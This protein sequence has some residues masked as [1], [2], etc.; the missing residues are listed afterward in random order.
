MARS[1]HALLA[2]EMPRQVLL[3]S[4]AALL[5]LELELMRLV[6]PAEKHSLIQFVR[7]TI[8]LFVLLADICM[9]LEGR[10]GMMICQGLF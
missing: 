2:S 7:T 5:D 4:G 3:G 6:L 10:S 8:A 9:G 1:L